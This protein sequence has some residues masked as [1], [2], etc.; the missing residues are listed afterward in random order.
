[1]DPVGQ[2]HFMYHSLKA[3]GGNG[4]ITPRILNLAS[5]RRQDLGVEAEFKKH[6]RKLCILIEV[7]LIE[8]AT[9]AC[10]AVIAAANFLNESYASCLTL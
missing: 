4:R 9:Q 5:G 3:N 8:E 1:M 6:G 10:L 2:T 7:L